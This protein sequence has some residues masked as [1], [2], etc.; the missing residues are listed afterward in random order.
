MLFGLA[1]SIQSKSIPVFAT[2]G[3]IVDIKRK[4]RGVVGGP[5]G[6]IR[7]QISRF[8]R[9]DCGHAVTALK[10]PYSSSQM[11]AGFLNARPLARMIKAMVQ[12]TM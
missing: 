4:C 1:A 11:E 2:I 8:Y 3:W 6:S 5:P 10:R 9:K 7:S 12:A